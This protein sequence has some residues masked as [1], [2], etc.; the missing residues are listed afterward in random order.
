[1]SSRKVFDNN[2]LNQFGSCFVLLN[3]V[4]F[5]RVRNAY[6]SLLPQFGFMYS[7]ISQFM[8]VLVCGKQLVCWKTL[9]YVE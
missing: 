9:A 7:V 1:M 2:I 5:G 6:F 3:G 8:S 4:C